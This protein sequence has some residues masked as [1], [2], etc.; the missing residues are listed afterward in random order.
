MCHE[1]GCVEASMADEDA[2]IDSEERAEYE[3]QLYQRFIQRLLCDLTIRE[4]I[5]GVPELQLRKIRRY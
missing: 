3:E 1:C 2:R 4:N 5:C